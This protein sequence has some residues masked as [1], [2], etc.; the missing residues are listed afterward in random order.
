MIKVTKE[1]RKDTGIVFG[2]VMLYFG[3]YSGNSLLLKISFAVFLLAVIIPSIYSFPAIVWFKISDILGF[4]VSKI[5]LAVIYLI[6]VFPVSIL[7]KV[8]GSDPM[9]IRNFG[10]TDSGTWIKREHEYTNSDFIKPF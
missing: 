9:M 2:L 3:I 5:V 8:F 10:K 4:V 6:V 7:R 1:M